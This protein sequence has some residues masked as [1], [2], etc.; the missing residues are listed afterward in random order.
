MTIRSLDRPLQRSRPRA[1]TREGER[2]GRRRFSLHQR[3]YRCP[4]PTSDAVERHEHRVARTSASEG[5]SGAHAAA[6]ERRRARSPTRPGGPATRVASAP[7]RAAVTARTRVRAAASEDRCPS[8]VRAGA[9]AD[10]RP[11]AA[12]DDRA[13]ST[14]LSAAS[15]RPS[16]ANDDPDLATEVRAEERDADGAAYPPAR[17]RARSAAA[18]ARSR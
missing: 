4:R 9:P 10:G 16:G 15:D 13:P 12:V 2:H 5:L 7:S 8:P 11:V 1:R 17:P 3:A 18:G 6:A 14:V